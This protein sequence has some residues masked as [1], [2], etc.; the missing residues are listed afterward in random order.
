MGQVRSGQVRSGQVRS[1]QVRSGQVIIILQLTPS[2]VGGVYYRWSSPGAWVL[3]TVVK[4]EFRLVNKSVFSMS[5][6]IVM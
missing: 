5:Y 6:V 2:G 1:G 4:L 3:T